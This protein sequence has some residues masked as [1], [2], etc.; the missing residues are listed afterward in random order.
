MLKVFQSLVVLFCLIRAY[1]IAQGFPIFS[2]FILF[3]KS[4]FD[5]SRFPNLYLFYSVFM[6]TTNSHFIWL[7]MS[8]KCRPLFYNHEFGKK[9]VII[10]LLLETP[11]DL[12]LET[13]RCSL[14]TPTSGVSNKNMWVHNENRGSAMKIWGSPVEIWGSPTRV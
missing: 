2:C 1:F 7:I 6:L 13:P 12:S 5:C 4:I 14:G 3:N 11:R 10:E 8:Y 9:I